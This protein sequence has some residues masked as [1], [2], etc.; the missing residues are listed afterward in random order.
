MINLFS[1]G[2]PNFESNIVISA[3]LGNV[4]R[5]PTHGDGKDRL[6]VL[7]ASQ[8][9][10]Y[11]ENMMQYDLKIVQNKKRKAFFNKWMDEAFTSTFT[12]VQI[13]FWI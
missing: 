8:L 12:A 9:E 11:F 1:E 7:E 3:Y 10:D 5:I 4:D 6:N 13:C 2:V